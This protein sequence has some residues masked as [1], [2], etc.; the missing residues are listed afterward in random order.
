MD[1]LYPQPFMFPAQLHYEDAAKFSAKHVEAQPSDCRET[2]I[3]AIASLCEY[4]KS[5]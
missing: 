4:F 2:S 5:I 1:Q 3:E